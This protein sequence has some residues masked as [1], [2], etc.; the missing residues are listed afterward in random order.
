MKSL[1]YLLLFFVAVNV[2]AQTDDEATL[3][4]IKEV[5]WPRAY[6]EQDN[7]LPDKILADEFKMIGSDGEYSDK[8]EQIQYV[9][10]HKPNYVSFK[11]KIK[12]LEI[13]EN[14][15]TTIC[16]KDEQGEYDLVY[17]SSNVLIKRNGTWKAI[18]SHTSGDQIVRTK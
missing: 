17:Q 12:R 14:R 16:R 6:S 18:S 11:F 7:I 3:R 13:F 1:F 4:H 8:A 15:T 9:R 5:E 10:T 2:K